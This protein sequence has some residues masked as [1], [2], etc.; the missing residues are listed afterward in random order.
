MTEYDINML[1]ISKEARKRSN[2][3]RKYILRIANNK[4]EICGWYPPS[5]SILHIHHI[6]PISDFLY[7]KYD[8]ID[9]KYKAIFDI[10]DEID[11]LVVLCP[12]CHYLI[13]EMLYGGDAEKKL[14][15]IN[16]MRKFMDFNTIHML[17]I[18]GF[19]QLRS[20]WNKF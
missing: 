14:F 9:K 6:I 16:H 11:N 10:K 19:Q 2:K 12:N 1:K 5:N 17:M 4:C 13:H 20:Q 7:K 15:C 18:I 8:V 3:L